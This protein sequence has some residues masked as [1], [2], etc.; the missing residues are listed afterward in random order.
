MATRHGGLVPRSR[1]EQ[2]NTGIADF[3]KAAMA[4][5]AELE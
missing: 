3:A 1:Q 2:W 4:A 5:T